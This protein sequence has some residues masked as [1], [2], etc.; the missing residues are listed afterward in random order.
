MRSPSQRKRPRATKVAPALVADTIAD[1]IAELIDPYRAAWL[2]LSPWER[3][4]RSWK[5]RERLVD[6]QA[7]HD[8]KTLPDL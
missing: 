7:V 3:L 6:P 1:P 2:A 5:L 8:A 4:L